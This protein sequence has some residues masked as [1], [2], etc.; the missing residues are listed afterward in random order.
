M[1]RK[2]ALSLAVAAIMCA[3]PTR[4]GAASRAQQKKPTAK[5]KMATVDYLVG[6]WSC[7]H[8]VGTFAGKYKTTY[9][10]VLGDLWLKQTYDFPPR[11]FGDNEGA[12]TGEALIGYDE[13]RQG[14]VRFLAVSNGLYFPIRMTD[15][16]NGWS[17]K[18]INYFAKTIRQEPAEGDARFTK[19]SDTEYLIDGPT[20]PENGTQVTEHHSCHKS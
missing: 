7:D 19:K 17:Y 14:W 12:I 15:T 8:T 3:V 1:K 11:Q 13:E 10:K 9:T 4:E 6:T 5:E 16:A 2:L 20:Y 18:Y